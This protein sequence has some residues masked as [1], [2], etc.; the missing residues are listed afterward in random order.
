MSAG[1]G[2]RRTWTSIQL[3]FS[4]TPAEQE[5]LDAHLRAQGAS[6]GMRLGDSLRACL[7]EAGV[8]PPQDA[9]HRHE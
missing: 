6:L 1:N 2:G 5:Q 7:I 4:L 9:P 3:Q 8:E